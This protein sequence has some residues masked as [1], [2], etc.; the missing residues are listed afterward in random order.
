MHQG[1]K[2]KKTNTATGHQIKSPTRLQLFHR[3][4]RLI[5][6]E[7]RKGGG[8]CGRAMGEKRWNDGG[9]ECIAGVGPAM[10]GE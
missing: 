9:G 5:Q 7:R 6:E 3:K 8:K 2:G 4:Q 10:G 1:R